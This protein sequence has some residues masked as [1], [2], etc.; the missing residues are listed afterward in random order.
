MQSEAP[1][2]TFVDVLL[3][4]RDGRE[5]GP[6]S[7]EIP[8]NGKMRVV[9]EEEEGWQVFGGLL[10]GLRRPIGG[11]LEEIRVAVVQW[12]HLLSE[13]VD[14]NLTI[15]EFLESP[16]APQF[17]WLDQRRRSLG[18]LVD[19]LG[20]T[21][22]EK[23]L[24]LKFL[25]EESIRKFIA[26]R[27]MLS[28]ADILLVDESLLT[29]DDRVSEAFLSRWN[30]LNATVICRV[31]EGRFQGAFDRELRLAPGESSGIFRL[32]NSGK[33]VNNGVLT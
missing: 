20:L 21:A 11:Y 10:S 29:E 18:V 1:V 24:A 4:D 31:R 17:V 15:N 2:L 14:R 27:I 32:D 25:S 3:R 8:R 30:D 9:C 6:L 33:G 16:D 23:K 19:K 26:L 12:D 22:R 28:R 5:Y 13:S 7:G